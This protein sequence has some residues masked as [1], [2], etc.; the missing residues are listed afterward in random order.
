MKPKRILLVTINYWPELT[1]IGKYTGEMAVWLVEHGVEVKVVTAPPYYPEWKV[2]DGYSSF[3]YRKD[4]VSGVSVMRCP[5]WVPDKLS[6]LKRILHLASFSITSFPVM[7]WTALSWRPNLVFVIEPTILCAPAAL[8]SAFACTAESWLHVQDFE[9]D[10]AF[11][12]GIIRSPRLKSILQSVESWVMKKFDRVSTISEQML[13]RLSLKQVPID[14]QQLF[15]NWVD[16]NTIYPVEDIPPLKSELGFP[17]GVS[18]L[19]Y[20]GNMGE[21]QGLEVIIEAAKALNGR[22]DLVF[23]LCGGGASLD[24]LKEA[25]F[26]IKNL[27][28][29]PLQPL[30]KLN[31]LLNLADIHLLPQRSDAEDLVMPSKLTNM[32]ASGKP[33][34]AIARVGTQV[35]KIVNE[36]G[37][38]VEPGDATSFVEA[39]ADL[40]DNPEKRK[41]LGARGRE[42]ACEKWEK[43]NVL[44]S[45][46][47]EYLSE[48]G[49]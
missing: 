49:R 39:I 11:E 31:G 30:S 35:E 42:I 16:V 41:E 15:Q 29:I 26:G 9:V 32:M 43:N 10:A 8:L 38:V 28:Y 6:G 37:V 13:K 19:L 21:K 24:R 34:V 3:L 45:A 33:V 7:I 4:M 2:S 46:F 25:S 18:I 48:A 47:H 23:L 40:M 5:L 17:A 1:G 27:R 44:S 22:D 20:S 36:C 12:L 14:R